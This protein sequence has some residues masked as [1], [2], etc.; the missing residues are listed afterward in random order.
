MMMVIFQNKI[1]YMPSMPPF[2]RSEKIEDHAGVCKP[3]EWEEKRIRASDGTELAL[4]VSG[5]KNSRTRRRHVIV[6]YFQG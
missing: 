1:I 4:C 2:S 3:V 5:I 6:L